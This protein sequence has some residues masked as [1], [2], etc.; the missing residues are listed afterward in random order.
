[1]KVLFFCSGYKLSGKE[2]ISLEVIK[3]LKESGHEVEVVFIAWNDGAFQQKLVEIGVRHYTV[4]LGWYYMSN[5]KW[6]L[7]SLINY[8]PAVFKFIKIRNRFKPDL[9]YFDS[10]RN[11]VLLKPFLDKKVIFHVHEAHAHNKVL[12]TSIKMLDSKVSKYIAVSD[13]IRKD[14]IAAKANGDKIVVVHNGVGSVQSAANHDK[15][16]SVLNIGIVGQVRKTKGHLDLIEAC[17]ELPADVEYKLHIYGSN[18]GAFVDEV[19]VMA[20]KTG[21]AK[22]TVWHGY[23]TDKSKIYNNLNVLV[24]P[25]NCEEAFAL[26]SLEAMMHQVPVI[27]YMSG[28]LQEGIIDDE[29]GFVLQDRSAKSITKKLVYLY[30]HQDK[31]VEMEAA[32]GKHAMANFTTGKMIEHIKEVVTSV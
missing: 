6:S 18:T 9:Y 8:L 7:D 31:L 1:M 23:E 24:V 2:Y 10:Y 5:L 16:D 27:A 3:G 30:H 32:A 26:N 25:S 28:G 19:K 4:K 21:V 14:L 29:T 22:H 13:F 20:E 17:A 12:R 15:P 11:I